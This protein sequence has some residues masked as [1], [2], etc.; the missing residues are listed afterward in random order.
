MPS[1]RTTSRARGAAFTADELEALDAANLALLAY[2]A[3]CLHSDATFHP[4]LLPDGPRSVG[5]FRLLEARGCDA[6]TR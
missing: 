1:S 4:E 5:W 2:G 3:R 6:L